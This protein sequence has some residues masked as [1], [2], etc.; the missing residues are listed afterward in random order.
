VILFPNRREMI[1]FRDIETA[2]TVLNGL[3]A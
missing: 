1:P 3:R 2:I